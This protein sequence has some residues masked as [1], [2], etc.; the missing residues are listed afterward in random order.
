MK[1]A[2][3]H[4]TEEWPNFRWECDRFA[5]ILPGIHFRR[6]QLIAAMANLGFEVRREAVLQVLTQDV[7]RSSAIEGEHLDDQQVRSSLAQRL[8]LPHAGLPAPDRKVEGVVDMMLDATQRFEEALTAERLFGWHNALFPQGYSGL[9]KIRVAQWRDDS[10]GPM[11]VVSGPIGKEKVHFEA[12]SAERVPQEMERFLQWFERGPDMDPVLKAG[13]AH[14]WF[15]TIHPFDDGNGRIGRAVADM[16]LAR[17]DGTEQRSYS[18]TAQIHAERSSYYDQLEVAQRG[19]L[20][21]TAWLAWF[22]ERLEAALTSAEGVIEVV[23]RKQQFWDNHRESDLN[24]RQTKVIN[25]L[26]DGYRGKLQRAKYAKIARC[27]DDTALRDLMDL[28]D[29]GI[30]RQEGVGRGTH[31]VLTALPITG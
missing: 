2:Y 22:V 25:R 26:F 11:V 14:L 4:L 28:V 13:I 17:A 12:P 7:S 23:R 1:D 30:L 6:G 15:V 31:Y 10:D 18:I 29:K 8:G 24:A 20:D 3:S 27:S 21:V 16:A 9:S 5:A 19:G